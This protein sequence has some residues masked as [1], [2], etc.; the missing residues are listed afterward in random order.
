MSR[1]A[2]LV[3]PIVSLLLVVTFLTMLFATMQLGVRPV[4]AQAADQFPTA[5]VAPEDA[6]A[7]VAF[8][9]DEKSDQWAKGEELLQRAG[10]GPVLDN[11]RDEI[12]ADS[13][14]DTLPLDAFLGGQG[15]VI[16]T[17][18]AITAAADATTGLTGGLTG[19][20]TDATPE[21]DAA[22]PEPNGV[23]FVLDARAPDT[24][25]IG[26]QSS[27]DDQA[28]EVGT[29]V[30]TSDYE[31]VEIRFVQG[32]D[33]DNSPLAVAQLDNDLIIIAQSPADLEPVI[34]TQA[35]TNNPLSE[36]E[37]FQQ[38][39]ES[40][41]GDYLVYSFIN[42]VAAGEAQKA[43][44]TDTMG[45]G[46]AGS[47]L[48][49]LKEYTALLVSADDPGFRMETVAI[50]AEGETLPP[51]ADAFASDLV[52][53]APADA[54]FFLDAMDLG[55]TGVL[56]ALG[57]I[58][59]LGASGST[60]GSV[61]TPGPDTT[62]EEFIAQAYK[63]A[64]GLVGVNLQTDLF[65]QLVGEYA[66]WIQSGEDPSS[67]SSLFVSGVDT[68]DTVT[69]AL[70][71][72]TLLIQGAVSGSADITT[73][74]VD[75]TDVTVIDAT[76]PTVPTIEY[77]VVGEQILLGVGDAIDNFVAGPSDT[78]ADNEQF[79][80]VLATLPDE[81]N[82]TLYVDIAQ[83]APLLQ[84][85][86]ASSSGADGTPVAE[87]TPGADPTT[88]DYSAVKAYALVAFDEDGNRRSSS[89]LY[90]EE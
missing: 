16:V 34:D 63:D 12:L 38:A 53:Q 33:A 90:I 51:A 45:L 87:G 81:G 40:L 48:G 22:A 20:A 37:P 66:L 68:P 15:A 74:E 71:Q 79:Q 1:S 24:A 78:L 44:G 83:I 5:A 77:G 10:F 49:G 31:G 59:I 69:A 55:Q 11:A 88:A 18:E 76:D 9:L 46:T 50:P 17:A 21:A 64:E 3:Q 85:L 62:Q 61:A 6:L 82:G 73:R 7:Y 19:E 39:R 36:F 80:T 57:L 28:T 8:T 13:G 54:L 75:G 58:A 65:R 41:D 32:D 89:I 23:A 4:S 70:K 29:P 72:L 27:L 84:A 56:D 52:N 60:G 25:L 43:S 2:R 67:I 26:I 14:T 86:S 35:G 42:G 30:A 47:E